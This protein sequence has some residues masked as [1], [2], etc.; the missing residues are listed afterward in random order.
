MPHQSNA[1]A[2]GVRPPLLKLESMTDDFGDIRPLPER[3]V[4]LREQKL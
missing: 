3:L 2:A 1:D 4:E